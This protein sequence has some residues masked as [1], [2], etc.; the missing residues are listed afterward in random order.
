MF[1]KYFYKSYNGGSANLNNLNLWV[2]KTNL[3]STNLFPQH[4]A[5]W[6][7][8]CNYK[9]CKV[10]KSKTLVR[11]QDKC[12]VQHIYFHSTLKQGRSRVRVRIRISSV[13]AHC[14]HLTSGILCLFPQIRYKPLKPKLGLGEL[15][16]PQ[17][18][19]LFISL[20]L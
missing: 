17:P 10:F 18:K 2:C 1:T 4:T 5:L 3:C 9:D 12:N 20:L 7:K 6:V 14:T 13:C 11:L 15:H 16:K 8:Q 19:C